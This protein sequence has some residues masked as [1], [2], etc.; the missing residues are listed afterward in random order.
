MP[1]LSE[2][3]K[4]GSLL[5]DNNGTLSRTLNA[6]H[7]KNSSVHRLDPRIKLVF[8]LA[9]IIYV[10]SLPGFTIKICLVFLP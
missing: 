10:V 4:E 7:Y 1:E 6:N 9:I 2:S 3:R 5:E 8:A